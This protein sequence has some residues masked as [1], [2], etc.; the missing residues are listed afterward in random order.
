MASDLISRKSLIDELQEELEWEREN[1]S[2]F[3]AT[4]AFKLSIKRAKEAPAVDAVEVVRCKDCGFFDHNG[5]ISQDAG[6][7]NFCEMVRLTFDYCSRG[8]RREEDA[9]D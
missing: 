4:H 1:Q 3:L 8:E 7:C 5:I 2:G 9:V 6:W